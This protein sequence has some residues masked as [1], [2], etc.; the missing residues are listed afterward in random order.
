MA[1]PVLVPGVDYTKGNYAYSP[2]LRKFVDGLPGMTAAG[3]NNLG[4]YIPVAVPD[5]TIYPGDDYYEIALVEYREQLHSDLAPVVGASKTDPNATGGVRLRG[6]VQEVNGVPVTEPHY[7]GPWI[8]AQSGRPVRVKFTNRLP[9]GSKGNLFLPVDT[10]IMGANTLPDGVSVPTQN[11][12]SVHLHGGIPGWIS[13]G[14]PNQWITPAGE[15]TPF[16]RG[17]TQRNVPDMDVPPEGSMTFY[18]P[19]GHSGRMLWYHDHTYGLTRLNVYAGEVSGYLVT[20]PFERALTTGMPEIPLVIQDKTFV[21]DPTTLAQQDP[22]WDTNT[23]GITGELWFPHVYVPNQDPTDPS[24]GNAL[25]RWDYGPWFWPPQPTIPVPPP[26]VS[27]VPESFHDTPVVNGTPY[28]YFEVDPTEYRF[29]ILNGANERYWNLQWYVADPSPY[30]NSITGEIVTNKEVRLLPANSGLPWPSYFPL[31]AGDDRWGLVPDPALAGPAMIQIGNETGVLPQ[32]WVSTNIPIGFDYN[33]RTIVVLNVQEHALLLGPAERADVIVDFTPYAGQTLILFNDAPAPFPA[34]DTRNGPY[35][36]APDQT[37]SGGPAA[38]QPGYG[39][40]VQTIMQVRVRGTPTGTPSPAPWVAGTLPNNWYNPATLTRLQTAVPAAFKA[41]QPV[42]VV[43]QP[44]FDPIGYDYNGNA[45]GTPAASAPLTITHIQDQSITYIPYGS[46]NPVTVPYIYK[47]IHELFDPIG[48]MNAVLG[49]ELPFTSYY[50]QTTLPL[51]YVDPATEIIAPGDTQFWWIAHNGVDTHTIHFHLVDVQVINRVGWD[52]AI[53]SDMI[54]P[55]EYGFKESVRMNPLENI[56]VAVRPR[57]PLLPFGIPDAI[58]PLDSTQPLGSINNFSGIDPYTGNAVTVTNELVNNKWEYMWHCHLLGHE[59]N[60]M[61][62]PISLTFDAIPP[63]A[64]VG[65]GLTNGTSGNLLT[66]TD[67]TPPSNPTTWGNPAN[68]IGYLVFKAPLINNGGALGAFSQIAAVPANRGQFVDTNGVA[69]AFVAYYVAAYNAAGTN[70]SPLVYWAGPA[71]TSPTNLTAT[72]TFGPGVTLNWVDTATNTASFVVERAFDAAFT[73]SLAQ[74]GTVSAPT[75]TFVDTTV[76]SGNQYWYRVSAKN[77]TGTS[78]PSLPATM[79]VYLPAAP[80]GFT[81]TLIPATLTNGPSINLAWLNTATNASAVVVTAATDAA[82]TQGL[83]TFALAANATN[84]SDVQPIKGNGTTNYYA[85]AT[86]NFVGASTASNKVAIHID[87]IPVTPT[88]FTIAILAGPSVRL[89]WGDPEAANLPTGYLILRSTDPTFLTGV[90]STT[91]GGAAAAYTDTT[92]VA[93]NVYYYRFYAFTTGGFSAPATGTASIASTPVGLAASVGPG[94][95]ISVGWSTP[96][97]VPTS[98]VLQRATNAAFTGTLVTVNPVGTASNYVDGTVTVG[99]TYYYRLAAV[100]GGYT[101]P[102]SAVVSA[103]LQVAPTPTGFAGQLI[104]ATTNTPVEVALSWTQTGTNVTGLLLT[105]A[106]DPAFTLSVRTI[107][108]AAALATYL[109]TAPVLGATNYYRLVATNAA[110]VSAQSATVALSIGL[111]PTTPTNLAGTVAAGPIVNLTWVNGAVAQTSITLTRSTNAAF[112]GTLVTQVLTGTTVSFADTAVTAN[113]TYYYRI[114]S[115]NTSG[116]SAVSASVTVV[117]PALPVAPTGLAASVTNTIG[118][119]PVVNLS[120][121]NGAAA[122]T[123]ITLQRATNAA[124]TGTVVS[125]TLAA[126]AVTYADTAVALNTTYYYRISASNVLGT[127]TPSAAVTAVVPALPTTPTGL[128]QGT[129]TTTYSGP[130][131]ALTWVN[132]AVP[133]T[134]VV[135]QRASNVGFTTGLTA[136]TVVGTATNYTD[137]A[138]ATN[139]TYYYRIS[140]VNAV[141]ISANSASVRVNVGAA[142]TAPSRLAS[143]PGTGTL[144]LT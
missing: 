35:T 99:V 143:T 118:V 63:L 78:A 74:I 5:T 70:A 57:T 60:D 134:S 129:I 38:T 131:V 83:R 46:T 142:V 132:G 89:T 73:V 94:L 19:N 144:A 18:W 110:S 40:N 114:S 27:A 82:F 15:N 105:A 51:A 98:Y 92:V 58:R 12:A 41:T 111:K 21:P 115:A 122:Q 22:L 84:F 101:T 8:V 137:T 9:T 49:T 34:F 62:R 13:D 16:A 71:P 87:G 61:M 76:K 3:A 126:N 107:N 68:E 135:V 75:T 104:A 25:G 120:W 97:I 85:V 113:T 127:S 90:V 52:G 130:A 66:W 48:R 116:F 128:A 72:L 100:S 139:T 39:P 30:T 95:V 133:Q 42:P 17:T 140:S 86:T 93:G 20:D 123:S 26:L 64:P 136:F 96:A 43:P 108:I 59:E 45:G 11:R 47:A 23:W 24:G 53:Y 28:P 36:G 31:M 124:F 37:D 106:T 112:T 88:P 10:T 2:P 80:T 4:Q 33:R 109:D 81:G 7:L 14:T 65:V 32:P 55:N 29:R 119:G 67:P 103:T 56:L 138:V 121:V 117:V 141:G 102:Y 69:N 54:D 1:T 91:L 6:Y 77:L 44:F 79:G 50:T 125:T